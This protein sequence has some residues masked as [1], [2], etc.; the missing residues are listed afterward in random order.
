MDFKGKG[1]TLNEVNPYVRS[2][3]VLDK[4]FIRMRAREIRKE[5]LQ[6]VK[7]PYKKLIDVSSGDA[8]MAG[9][10]PISFLRQVLAVCLYP[11]LLHSDRFPSDVEQRAQRLLKN[12]EGGSLGSYSP[13]CGIVSI[14]RSVS[15][16]IS[17]RDGGV[18]SDPDNIF[19]TS[20]GQDAIRCILK[21]LVHG[22][23]HAQTGVLMPVP[24]YSYFKIAV[25][26][27]GGAIVPYHLSEEQG[28]DMQ[29][30]ELR[31]ALQTARGHC[32]PRALYIINP[33]NPTGHV[34]SR[35]SI[36]EVIRFA[37]EEKLFLLVDEVYQQ[38]VFGE[39]SAF[40]SYKKVLY[41]MG[42]SYSDMVELAS[43][44][45][46]SK[47][48]TGECGL[49]CG[50]VEFVNLDPE[51]KKCAIRLFE[52]YLSTSITGQIALDI[53]TNP[54]GHEDPSYPI[55]KAES[56]AILETLAHNA[57]RVQETLDSLPGVSYQ[58]VQGSLYIFPRL[59]LPP[60]AVEQARA[61][62]MEPD[63]FYCSRLLEEAGVCSTPGC[64]VGQREGTY[65]IRLCNLVPLDTMEDMLDRLNSF[66]PRF[67]QEF[68]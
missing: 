57:R 37:A 33:G 32:S 35:E 3:K 67:M 40:V 38:T 2:I 68:S 36:E 7:K 54:P 50:Y 12:C 30:N 60:R 17:Q 39:G 47:G 15:E 55:F 46:V 44:H 20:G 45:S 4:E 56:Q 18:P 10:K 43:L 49:R 21:I 14:R 63:R 26:E 11:E 66:H 41:E 48:F 1:L 9:M 16:F 22:E 28:W 31:R 53:M 42:P 52:M 24:S 61:E 58:P 59:H 64:D 27:V 5:L 23:G 29:V 13:P 6:G 34:Q 25:L 8:H 51:V 62:G 19:I 65:H